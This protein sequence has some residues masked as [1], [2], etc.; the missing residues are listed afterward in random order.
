MQNI[1]NIIFYI[2]D[3]SRRK[4]ELVVI[5]A[6]IFI[7]IIATWIAFFIRLDLEVLI[8]P[9]DYLIIPFLLS[10][11]LFLPIFIFFNIY[12]SIFRYFDINSLQKLSS[13]LLIYGI[14]YFFII[15]Y[16]PLD[17]VP[18]SIGIIQP[19]IF[20]IMLS[21]S[22]ILYMT[23]INAV[24]SENKFSK[25]IIIYGAGSAG[26]QVESLISQ[27]GKY[28]IIGFIDDDIN[29]VGR[30]LLQHKI[31]S[32][33]EIKNDKSNKNINEIL[34][35][36]TN[37][38]LVKKKQLLNKL[39]S[40]NINIKILPSIEK[41]VDGKINL[42]DFREIDVA[43]LI[44]RKIKINY[45]FLDSEFKMKKIVITGAG[46]S[47]G[48]ELCKQ[49]IKF[50][51]NKIL[52]IDNSEFNLYSIEKELISFIKSYSLKSEIIPIL[53]S[54][55]KKEQINNLFIDFK[56][57]FVFH[58]AAYKHVTMV[59]KNIPESI[60]N[61]LFGTINVVNA[62]LNTDCK[63]FILISTDKAVRPTSVMGASK[64]LSEIYVQAVN[65]E[66]KNKSLSMVRFGNV[67]D[68]SGSVIPLFREQINSGGP[69]TVTHPE[70]TRFFMT[71]PEAAS[72]ILQAVILSKGGEVFLLDMGKPVKILDLAK[73]MISL[74][75][76]HIKS[77][78]NYDSPHSIDI[79]FT[80]LRQGEKL[81]EELLISSKSAKRINDNILVANEKFLEYTVF[82]KVI[83]KIEELINKN[84]PEKL[85]K[86]IN[87]NID[88]FQYEKNNMEK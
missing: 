75:G 27:I 69:I 24:L 6:D 4:K 33:E 72:L 18:R 60:R 28:K 79:I 83:N 41:L 65:K 8:Y 87:N 36:I 1:K 32:F 62:F 35:S 82:I 26:I 59:E 29:K 48:S 40:L 45:K 22:R 15:L 55:N 14:I 86:L 12:N 2:L 78:N 74:S 47:I 49:I 43:D 21:I 64:R 42:D 17:G 23:I 10:I 53:L 50:E 70:V 34:V 7:A 85:V 57:D 30:R 52:L 73:K 58:A 80:G 84:E 9:R 66:F 20:F 67:L 71:I 31:Y 11:L 51:P 81:Y 25:N 39:E 77:E 5:I 63:K 19:V 56:P 38:D 88:E 61:N 76:Y 54:I 46:G 16:F 3:L 13:S 44:E 68:S 37:L